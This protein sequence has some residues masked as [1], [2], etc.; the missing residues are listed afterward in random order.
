M[1]AGD[2]DAVAPGRLRRPWARSDRPIPRT[3]LRPLQRFLL[4]EQAGGLLLVAAAA[5]ALALANSPW[6]ADVQRLWHTKLIV[7]TGPL[8]L[9]MD[10]RHWIGDGLMTLFFFVVGLE[11]KRELATGELRDRRAAALPVM[12][13]VGGMVVPA[14]VY[15]AF[16]AGTDHVAGWG[17]PIAT[18]VA[19]AV[20]VL[21]LVA[22]GLPEGVRT[23]LLAAAIVDDIGSIVIIGFVY[24]GG[25]AWPPLA[26]AVGLLAIVLVLRRIHVRTVASYVVLGVGIWLAVEQSGIHP[27][28]VGA[29]LGLLTPAVPFQ[30]PMAVSAEAH[31]V[32]DATVDD[33]VPPD[34]DA[35]EWLRLADLSREA[36]SP[37]ARLEAVLH[38]WTSFVIV[39]LFA[40]ANAGV[41]V[42]TLSMAGGLARVT[43]GVGL[44]LVVGK[45]VGVVLG[46]LAA[47]RFAKATLPAGARWRDL[48]GAALLAGIGFTVSLVVAGLALPENGGSTAARAGIL[49]GSV[50]AAAAGALV[51]RLGRRPAA[52]PEEEAPPDGR[53]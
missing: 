17:I 10:L 3:V 25:V 5:V 14:L 51:L 26:V 47:L 49:L 34:V 24:T 53:L 8:D 41:R 19:F 6:N 52:T 21:A 43:L 1:T 22:P 13:A 38:P 50:V 15:L 37:L 42:G 7:R 35:H 46:A 23:F 2:P 48:V 29:V 18:D 33:P 28:I 11:I 16:N 45:S 30:R 12:A 27:T 20:G 36:V 40:L 31:R 9:S 32:A 39:P 44:G 4:T